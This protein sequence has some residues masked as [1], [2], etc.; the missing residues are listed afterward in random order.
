[1]IPE[2]ILYLLKVNIAL[3]LFY[4]GYHFILQRYTFHSL[5]RLY[6]IMGLIYSALYPLINLSGILDKNE[7]LK[8]KMLILT[9]DWQNS[10]TGVMNNAEDQSGR[11]WQMVL[12]IFWTGVI[13]MSIRLIIQLFFLLRLHLQSSSSQSGDIQ[14]RKV[15]KVVNPFSFWR[16]IYVNPD[17]H[18]SAEL[19]SILE[20]ERVHVRQFHTFDVLLAE[21]STI[22][23]WFNPGVWLMRKA[24]KANLEFITDQ[25]VIRSGIDRKDYQYA[26]LKINIIPQNSLP[27]NNFHFLTIKK[28][29]AMI[30]KKPT[31]KIN[32]GG[33]LLL[34]P[35][36][37]LFVL[38]V[39]ASK[40]S[41]AIRKALNLPQILNAEKLT[42]ADPKIIQIVDRS[43]KVDFTKRINSPNS[44]IAESVDSV[45]KI[46]GIDTTKINTIK[47][48]AKSGNPVVTII[49]DSLFLSKPRPIYIIDG[50]RAFKGISHVSPLSL[51]PQ[52]DISSIE[53]LKGATA[54]SLYGAEGINGVVIITTKG[55]TSHATVPKDQSAILVGTG[56]LTP[57]E[58]LVPNQT[59]KISLSTIDKELIILD[60]KEATKAEIN[61][62]TVSSIESIS[63]IKGSQAAIKYGEKAREGVVVIT[64]KR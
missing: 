22:F 38:I 52:E 30:N 57:A 24:I 18:E 55:F 4:M 34:L 11:Y 21:L 2:I 17:C 60:G 62:L 35:A 36:I 6:L 48:K 58:G 23:Y 27:I 51:I 41:Q 8:K 14:F 53:V 40:G 47:V 16:A 7:V 32:L 39:S 44:L 9:P 15:S 10:V 42:N 43:S 3:V 64:T 49:E 33:Y 59:Q 28:R 5:N 13:F 31:G 61:L 50:V 37:M 45:N 26:L 56:K 1:M 54:T 63:V 46:S 29:I 25:E 20:H 19:R 12:M